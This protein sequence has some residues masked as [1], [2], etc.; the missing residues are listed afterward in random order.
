MHHVPRR[1]QRSVL[2]QA[3]ERVGPGGRLLYKDVGVRPRWRAT[4]SRMHDLLIA[5]E[6]IHLV[7]PPVIDEWADASGLERVHHASIDM[8]W[9]GHELRVYERR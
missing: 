8:L 9:Y 2:E 4:A 1:A 6:W 3:A 5:R 7:D